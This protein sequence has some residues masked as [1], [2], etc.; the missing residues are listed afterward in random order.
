MHDPCPHCGSM[1][2]ECEPGGP[3]WDCPEQR[4]TSGGGAFFKH[5]QQWTPR[6]QGLIDKAVDDPFGGITRD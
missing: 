5:N 4:R 3:W 2:H 1:D 6:R